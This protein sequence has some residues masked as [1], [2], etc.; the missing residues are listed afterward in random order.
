MTPVLS[1]FVAGK[2]APG[3]SNR[4][5]D[6][7]DP[8][9]GTVQAQVP[10]A[11]AEE[12]DAAV[13]DAVAAQREWARWNPQ[14]R[15]RVLLRFLQLANDEIDSLAA[16]LSGE[17]GKTIPDAKGDIQR[18]LEVIEFAAGAP[19][20]PVGYQTASFIALVPPLWRRIVDPLLA[21]WDARMANDAER[22]LVAERGWQV[23]PDGDRWFRSVARPATDRV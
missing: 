23:A 14:R 6:V 19:H 5:S 15:A 21:D 1:H 7:F 11:S 10:L 4:F 17:H 20:L 2:R 18:G 16:L 8:N 9:T 22:A 13:A 3:T 12:V